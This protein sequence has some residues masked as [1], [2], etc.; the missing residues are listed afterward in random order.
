MLD[1]IGASFLVVRRRPSWA[2]S[3]VSSGDRLLPEQTKVD[4]FVEFVE[5]YESRL[6]HALPTFPSVPEVRTPWFEPALPA[7]LAA[8]PERER[9]VVLLLHE[10]G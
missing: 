1:G 8:L 5:T 2:L 7:A 10:Y 6:R 3:S 9:T 4:D